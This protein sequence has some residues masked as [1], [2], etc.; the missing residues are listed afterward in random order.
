MAVPL[1]GPTSQADHS[2]SHRPYIIVE[3]SRPRV[4]AAHME[5][6]ARGL[7]TF[8]DFLHDGLV[9]YLDVNEENDSNIALY[10]KDITAVSAPA[11]LRR[12]SGRGFPRLA[13]FYARD[14]KFTTGFI[15]GTI[16]NDT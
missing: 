6:L 15:R 12:W 5:E 16:Y 4:T 3:R 1:N 13:N 8:Q 10:E 14:G 11:T 7:R 2:T 9:E